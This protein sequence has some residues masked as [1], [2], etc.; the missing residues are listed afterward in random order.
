MFLII[1]LII[2]LIIGLVFGL[3]ATKDKEEAFKGGFY[4]E[5]LL[6][7]IILMSMTL[8][9]VMITWPLLIIAGIIDKKNES[10]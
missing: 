8:S 6:G 9:G 3:I 5:N 4:E 7:R 1:C 10:E 2:C